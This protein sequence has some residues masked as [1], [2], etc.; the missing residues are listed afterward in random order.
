MSYLLSNDRLNLAGRK[1]EMAF[2]SGGE[3][4]VCERSI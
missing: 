3:K 4:S 2:V 1:I